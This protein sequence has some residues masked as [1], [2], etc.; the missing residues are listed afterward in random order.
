MRGSGM[1]GASCAALNAALAIAGSC[2][3]FTEMAGRLPGTEYPNTSSRS[4]I[5]DTQTPFRDSI[6]PDECTRADHVRGRVAVPRSGSFAR[7]RKGEPNSPDTGAESPKG[8]G[9]TC[10]ETSTGRCSVQVRSSSEA[11]GAHAWKTLK[12]K[13]LIHA[14]LDPA[15]E[16][17]VA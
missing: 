4:H 5:S 1:I 14:S 8:L 2:R 3:Q 12:L 16:A 7:Q 11:Q 15:T 17:Q 6:S 9:T 10:R 13:L